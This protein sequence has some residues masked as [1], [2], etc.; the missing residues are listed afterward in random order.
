[1]H[2]KTIDTGFRAS[3]VIITSSKRKIQAYEDGHTEQVA[4]GRLKRLL[5]G[6]K[7]IRV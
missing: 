4:R 1:M 6:A 7:N 3:A 2:V 5:T